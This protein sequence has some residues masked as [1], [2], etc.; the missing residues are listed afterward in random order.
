MPLAS[1]LV[2]VHTVQKHNPVLFVADGLCGAVFLGRFVAHVNVQVFTVVLK[3]II[4]ILTFNR[5][6]TN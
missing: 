3:E 2:K 6:A 4:I 1:G 5:N